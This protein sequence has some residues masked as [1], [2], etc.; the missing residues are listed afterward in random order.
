MIALF[1]P[2]VQTC[3]IIDRKVVALI[4]F[5]W[6]RELRVRSSLEANSERKRS[7]CLLRREIFDSKTSTSGVMASS[8]IA[9]VVLSVPELLPLFAGLLLWHASAGTL[10]TSSQGQWGSNGSM[11]ISVDDGVRTTPVSSNLPVLRPNNLPSSGGVLGMPAADVIGSLT[12]RASKLLP[13]KTPHAARCRAALCRVCA[14]R[15]SLHQFE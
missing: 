1:E 5:S 7:V 11:Q 13:I 2:A 10:A 14:A 6:E 3:P 8:S 9:V 12:N 15:F 4:R